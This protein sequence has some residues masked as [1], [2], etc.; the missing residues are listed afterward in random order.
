MKTITKKKIFVLLLS[1]FS[2]VQLHAQVVVG[3]FYQDEENNNKTKVLK[4][5]YNESATFISEITNQHKGTLYISDDFSLYKTEFNFKK[6][7]REEMQA[8]LENVIFI[9]SGTNEHFSEIIVNIK[10]K[11][12]TEYLFEDMS[13]KEYFAVYEKQPEMKWELLD[14]EKNIA[15]YKCKKA[16]T[17]FR[18]RSY[19]VWYTS[20]IPV[21]VGPWKFNGLPGLILSVKDITSEYYTWEVTSIKHSEDEYFNFQKNIDSKTKFKKISYQDFDE[22]FIEARKDD[23]KAKKARVSRDTGVYFGF[24]TSR[25]KEPINEWRTQTNFE[26]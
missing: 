26:F 19:D 17:T 24:D 22:K 9:D 14:G 21:S 12:L 2:I 16:K 13:L 5:E 11:I 7:D 25:N 15:N 18:G 10:E 3:G 1:V 23:F 8:K 20:E 6:I 4:V